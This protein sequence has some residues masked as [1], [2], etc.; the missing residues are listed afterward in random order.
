MGKRGKV[1]KWEHR[2]TN[3]LDRKKKGGG[4]TAR[5]GER[6]SG[7]VEEKPSLLQKLKRNFLLFVTKGDRTIKEAAPTQS[8][9]R[10]KKA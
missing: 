4:T 5:N 9:K 3:Q 7:S 6:L 2:A 10:E 8:Q 1:K